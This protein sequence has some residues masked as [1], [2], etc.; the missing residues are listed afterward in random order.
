MEKARTRA[1]R[2]DG[3]KSRELILNAAARLATIEGLDGI[4]I[5]R[6]AEHIGMSKSGLYAHFGSKEELQL[7]TIDKAEEIFQDEVVRPSM[8]EDPIEMI[9]QLG[10]NFLS[11]LERQVFPGGCF[12]A[13]TSA[14]FGPK[15]GPIHSKVAETT[16]EWTDL[17]IEL[18]STA[19]ASGAIRP[20]EDVSQL[21]FELDSFLLLANFGFVM[22]KTLEPLERGRRAYMAR[23]ERAKTKP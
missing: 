16:R 8:R 4:S 13:Y 5:G 22:E 9:V 2:S 18:L 21:A 10:E 15:S 14:E 19:Q 17:F 1:E 23:L 11:H 12:F 7:A 3:I 20:D 6:L